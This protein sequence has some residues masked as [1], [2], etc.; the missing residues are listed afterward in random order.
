MI[1]AVVAL[2]SCHPHHI[3]KHTVATNAPATFKQRWYDGF[4][5]YKLLVVKRK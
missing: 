3:V 2:L 4:P 5:Q 1:L